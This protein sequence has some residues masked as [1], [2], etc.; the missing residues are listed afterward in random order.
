MQMLEETERYGHP[1][2][3]D[4]LWEIALGAATAPVQQRAADYRH[5]EAFRNGWSNAEELHTRLGVL[6]G[7]WSKPGAASLRQRVLE[8]AR[9]ALLGSDAGEGDRGWRLLHGLLSAQLPEAIELA[10]RCAPQTREGARHLFELLEGRVGS[11]PSWLGQY[12][13][14][15]PELFLGFDFGFDFVF[16]FGMRLHPDSLVVRLARQL[17]SKS[18]IE[19]GPDD[20]RTI[21]LGS[22][23]VDH[24][25]ALIDQIPSEPGWM[26]WR[27]LAAFV[28]SPSHS[29]LADLLDALD[30]ESFR[31]LRFRAWR[32]PWPLG[33]CLLAATTL[34]ETASF[35]AMLRSGALGTLDDWTAAEARWRA[36]PTVSADDLLSSLDCPGPWNRDIAVRN[37]PFMTMGMGM[38]SSILPILLQRLQHEG[39]LSRK[40]QVL[41][42]PLT[43]E[44]VV[45]LHV[46]H[47]VQRFENGR[48]PLPLPSLT[49]GQGSR[50]RSV[51][52]G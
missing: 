44:V 18:E 4:P 42:R 23:A 20:Q 43:F 35:S 5:V 46:A 2:L 3:H 8:H 37:V 24:D 19:L 41:L 22:L 45:P 30:D 21:S 1:W 14:R 12:I 50:M 38:G 36:H 15:N 9:E 10:D 33:A 32:L 40:E 26:R 16:A 31:D 27:Q 47:L 34:E 51:T 6:A 25:V 28:A 48:W 29:T 52:S 11:T 39:S 13:D 49:C 17:R 7:S